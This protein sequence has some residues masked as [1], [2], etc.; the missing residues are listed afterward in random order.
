MKD[1]FFSDQFSDLTLKV[2]ERSFKVH[3]A[4]LCARSAV[5]AS[6]ILGDNTGASTIVIRDCDPG[7]FEDVLFYLYTGKLKRL[8]HA[9]VT[10]LSDAADK[11][12][13]PALKEEC[14]RFKKEGLSVDYV[15]DFLAVA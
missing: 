4:I 14:V 6:K 10:A 3:K 9:N 12:E 2:Q 1:L 5:F 7:T 13:I 8:S 15:S 11:F